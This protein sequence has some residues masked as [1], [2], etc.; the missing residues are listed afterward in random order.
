MPNSL[1]ATVRSAETRTTDGETRRAIMAAMLR[2]GAIT[3][4]SWVKT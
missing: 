1:S 3:A 2:A 4:S